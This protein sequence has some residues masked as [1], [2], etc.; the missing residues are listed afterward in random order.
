MS[1]YNIDLK[2]TTGL[3]K[4]KITRRNKGL[5]T[6]ISTTQGTGKVTDPPYYFRE[7]DIHFDNR[8]V[9]KNYPL[10]LVT[11]NSAPHPLHTLT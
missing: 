9:H 10:H 7:S 1:V 3:L 8:R 6:I 11:F 5:A 4:A 2:Q